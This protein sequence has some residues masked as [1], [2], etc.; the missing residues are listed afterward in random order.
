MSS[1]SKARSTPKLNL[2]ESSQVLAYLGVKTSGEFFKMC[3]DKLRP[4]CIPA[5]PDLFYREQFKSWNEFLKLGA[6]IPLSAELKAQIDSERDF[7]IKESANTRP[8][9][10]I[11]STDKKSTTRIIPKVSMQQAAMMLVELG[12]DSSTALAQLVKDRRRPAEVPSR[13]DLFYK[14]DFISWEHFFKLGH[15]GIKKSL[16]FE[17][18]VDFKTLSGLVFKLGINNKVDFK[19]AIK[20][21]RLPP[22]TPTMP[23]SYYTDE[24][25]NWKDFLAPKAFYVCFEEARQIARSYKFENRHQ[26][27]VFCRSGNLPEFIPKSPDREYD[28]FTTWEN[29]L[30]DDSSL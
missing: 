19:K 8:G 27:V 22:L 10:S 2:I 13:P 29:F 20:D 21:G 18:I 26:W 5:R 17:S 15:E 28:E 6:D 9:I 30:K 1:T 11:T 3:R 23:D 25:T 4:F 16:K 24:W 14:K 7:L 12:V